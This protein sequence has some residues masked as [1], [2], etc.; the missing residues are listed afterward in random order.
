MKNLWIVALMLL[1]L[2]CDRIKKPVENI[3]TAE[4][5]PN[6]L[7]LVAEDLGN[8]IPP[9]GDSTIQTPNLS[10]LAAEG[11]RYTNVYSVSGVCA[12]SRAALATG[13]YPSSIGAHNMR[14]LK[15]V[16]AATEMHGLIDYECVLP[17]EVKMA[18]EILRTNGYYCTNN[19]KEDYQFRPS[20]MAWDES[21]RYAHWRNNPEDKPFF[22]IFNFFVTHESQI[23]SP[24]P[25]QNFGFDDETFPRQRDK[26]YEWVKFAKGEEKPL[27]VPKDLEVK[28]P[29]YLPDTE[30][31]RKDMRRLYSNIVELDQHIGVVLDQLE[32]DGELENTIVVW[33]TD[34]GGPLPRQKRLLYNSGLQVPMIIRYPNQISAGAVDDQL[35]SFVDFAPTLLSMAGIQPPDYIQGQAFTGPYQ[36]SPRTY[37]HAAADRFDEQ[38]DMIRAV[39][40]NRFKYLKN[41]RPEQGYYLAVGYRERMATMQELLRLRDE[42]KL[43]EF[44]AQWFRT[45]KPIE[46]LFDT[47]NDPHELHN[48]ANDPKYADRLEALR[49]ECT[50]WMEAINDLGEINELA[51][52]ENFWP[53]MQQ[54]NTAMPIAILKDGKLNISCKT[55]G[56]SI[57][58]K[59]PED[60]VAGVGWRVY[61]E[62]VEL[63][64]G[65]SIKIIS[66]RI[67]YTP[68]DTLVFAQTE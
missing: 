37:I 28:L 68:S 14:T 31:T 54:P 43:D 9:F 52:I 38:Y 7:W 40:D 6:I 41:F 67:G 58:Y 61:N 46:E 60:E 16:A 44:Q 19:S 23:F 56:A 59:L 47:K 35:I 32:A 10:R 22:S 12:P 39:R 66:H 24:L 49:V 36:A 20:K 65:D 17:P 25:S 5:P 4:K 26:D 33:Y 21:S 34:H 51:L 3:I 55:E 50:R 13:M 53:D 1:S 15:Q 29:P 42:K 63:E 48:L 57:G 64:G 27:Y 62:P 8:Y 2:A 30:K 45:S 18:S 11:V